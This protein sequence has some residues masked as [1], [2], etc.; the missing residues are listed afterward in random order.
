MST[1]I[2]PLKFINEFLYI[3][4]LVPPIDTLEVTFKI[5]HFL[6]CL[7]KSNAT[8]RVDK[9]LA[10]HLTQLQFQLKCD[11]HSVAK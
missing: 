4:Y 2:E 5:S 1:K 9:T 10:S 8:L 6:M 7:T 3:Y 11:F